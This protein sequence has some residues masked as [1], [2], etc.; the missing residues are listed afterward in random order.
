MRNRKL[1]KGRQYDGQKV[2]ER[3]KR[4]TIIYKTLHRKLRIHEPTKNK[5]SS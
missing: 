3:A 2:K 4:Q 1:K 5:L